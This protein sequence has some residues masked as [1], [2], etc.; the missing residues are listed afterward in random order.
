M[1]NKEFGNKQFRQLWILMFTNCCFI[2]YVY[3][4]QDDSIR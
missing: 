3:S 1:T 4:F 2:K